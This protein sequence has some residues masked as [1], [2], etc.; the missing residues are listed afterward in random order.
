M[1]PI[2]GVLQP[3]CEQKEHL[4]AVYMEVVRIHYEIVGLLKSVRH[5]PKPFRTVLQKAKGAHTR[6]TRARSE[7]ERHCKTHGC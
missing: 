5:Q 6:C 7:L 2:P 3:S 4:L 1:K